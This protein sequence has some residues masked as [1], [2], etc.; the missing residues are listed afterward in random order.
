LLQKDEKEL[1]KLK[2]N[3]EKALKETKTSSEEAKL[4]SSDLKKSIKY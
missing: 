3:I 2:E 1:K 4:Y